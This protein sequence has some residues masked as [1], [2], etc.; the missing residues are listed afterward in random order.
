MTEDK[1]LDPDVADQIGEL[2]KLKG[3]YLWISAGALIRMSS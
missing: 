1:G 2:V 3:G